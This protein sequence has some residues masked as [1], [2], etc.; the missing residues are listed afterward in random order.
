M[1]LLRNGTPFS[2]YPT[3]QA[4]RV[5]LP[6]VFFHGSQDFALSALDISFGCFENNV[7]Q[8][9]TSNQSCGVYLHQADCRGKIGRACH[10]P[11]N[12]SI[13]VKCIGSC[14]LRCFC[15]TLTHDNAEGLL[16]LAWTALM[17]AAATCFYGYE[18]S[19]MNG[20]CAI[21]DNKP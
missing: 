8:G 7:C 15:F 12:T 5:L 11:G 13:D 1:G 4:L 19:R 2:S 6:A 14:D 21:E 10:L 17:L 16:G 20:L 18:A 9:S 3:L